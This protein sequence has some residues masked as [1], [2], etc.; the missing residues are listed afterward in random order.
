MLE[1]DP[2]DAPEIQNVQVK[3]I[4]TGEALRYATL[5]WISS[6]ILSPILML[7]INVFIDQTGSFNGFYNTV[8]LMVFYGGIF[9]IPNWLLF[10]AGIVVI[11]R[12]YT[13]STHIRWAAQAWAIIL[14]LLLFFIIFGVRFSGFLREVPFIGFFYLFTL[15]IGIW[16]YPIGNKGR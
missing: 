15:T 16:Y 3:K 1:Q 4:S 10:F 5:V 2:L 6:V 11:G 13:L 14:T 12:F 8:F 7:F 9:S